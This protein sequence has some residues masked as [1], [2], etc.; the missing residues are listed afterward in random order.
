MYILNKLSIYYY[1]F[2]SLPQ[3]LL[4]HEGALEMF[5]QLLITNFPEKKLRLRVMFEVRYSQ[6]SPTLELG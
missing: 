3:H 4:Q 2:S 1:L 6:K 5:Y